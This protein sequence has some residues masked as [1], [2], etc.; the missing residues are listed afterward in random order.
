[1]HRLTR[2]P[3]LAI[4]TILAWA[5]AFHARTG[6]WPKIR[7]GR[8]PRSQ[9]LNWRG[10][11]HLLCKGGRGL[12]GNSSLAQLLAEHRG[13]RNNAR[14]PPLTDQQILEW[15]DAHQRRTGAWPTHKSGSIAGTRGDNW[16]A[17]N[18]T[19]CYG[20][21]GQRGGSSL[22]KLLAKHR[23]ARNPRHR[24]LT[25]QQ[26][27]TWADAFRAGTGHWPN[28]DSGRVADAPGETW[29]A[30]CMALQRGHRGLPG[31]SSLPRLLAARSGARRLRPPEGGMSIV[32][33]RSGARRLGP[34]EGSISE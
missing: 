12:P 34:P 29:T 17:V 19:P 23:G 3:V 26:I 9:G 8:I 18:A 28:E 20:R 10:V 22:G 6:G 16:L 15:A 27:L 25:V 14:L 7:S 2:S 21:K 33:V 32:A 31:H 13:V 1:M 5:D 24:P 4:S 30:V 11:N